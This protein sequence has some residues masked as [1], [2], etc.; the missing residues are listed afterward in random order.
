MENKLQEII[1]SNS[2]SKREDLIPILQR[3]QEEFN[4]LPQEAIYA[5]SK[6][7][8]MPASKVYSI[9]SF[10]NLF[11]FQAIG[12]YHIRVCNGTACHLSKS[13]DLLREIKKELKIEPGHATSNRLFSLETVPCMGACHLSPIVR[14]NNTYHTQVESEEIK[15]VIAEIRK[16]EEL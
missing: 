2:N 15:R 1:T 7:L 4:Y 8:E 3:I 14:I 16:E 9:A 5:V 13:S 12:K 10:Y 11:R 6:A